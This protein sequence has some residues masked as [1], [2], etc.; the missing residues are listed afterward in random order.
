MVQIRQSSID[1]YLKL[2]EM[3]VKA[4]IM[5]SL[6]TRDDFGIYNSSELASVTNKCYKILYNN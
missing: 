6:T 4:D 3:K 2:Q 1:K 5:K